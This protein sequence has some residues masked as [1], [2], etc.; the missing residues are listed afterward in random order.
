[1]DCVDIASKALWVTLREATTIQ[2]SIAQCHPPHPCLSQ[3]F[4]T[5]KTST[6]F[7][8]GGDDNDVPPVF[9]D[10]FGLKGW[11]SHVGGADNK[12]R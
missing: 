9:V 4:Q 11:V 8:A 10:R 5:R 2:R 6:V 3:L 7:T 12:V 1:M